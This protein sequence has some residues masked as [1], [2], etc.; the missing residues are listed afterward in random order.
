M[1]ILKIKTIELDDQAAVIDL[2][3]DNQGSI[4]AN[5]ICIQTDDDCD[6][7]VKGKIVDDC[8]FEPVALIKLED[9][10]VVSNITAPG[11]Y[12]GEINAFTAIE[13]D[14]TGEAVIK[15]LVS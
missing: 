6:I 11:I 1:K 2:M 9:L 7:E 13:F 15:L 10:S 8:D 14:G 5:Q 3:G 4:T 12:I